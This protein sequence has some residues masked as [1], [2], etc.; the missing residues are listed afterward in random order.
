MRIKRR[1]GQVFVIK[2]EKRSG[3]P[4]AVKG[5]KINLS[6]EEILRSIEDGRRKV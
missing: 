5:V 1:D 6:R 4:L 2:P 3:S